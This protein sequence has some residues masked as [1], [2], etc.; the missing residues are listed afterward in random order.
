MSISFCLSIL[1]MSKQLNK[2]LIN[3]KNNVCKKSRLLTHSLLLRNLL[4][5]L[6]SK[7]N[8]SNHLNQILDKTLSMLDQELKVK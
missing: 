1:R 5:K 6:Q 7:Y 3:G 4:I 8:G 2:N